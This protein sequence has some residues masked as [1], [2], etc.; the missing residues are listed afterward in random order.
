LRLREKCDDQ[1]YM[2]DK[3]HEASESILMETTGEGEGVLNWALI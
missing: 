2:V 1:I 3:K